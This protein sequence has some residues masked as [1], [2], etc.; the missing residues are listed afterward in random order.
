MLPFTGFTIGTRI[1]QSG[2]ILGPYPKNRNSAVKCYVHEV[3]GL[4]VYKNL[5]TKFLIGVYTDRTVCFIC[6]IPQVAVRPLSEYSNC[7][8]SILTDRLKMNQIERKQL[9]PIFQCILNGIMQ[10]HLIPGTIIQQLGI[11][12]GWYLNQNSGVR[13]YVHVVKRLNSY[14]NLNIEFLIGVDT[15]GEPRFICDIPQAAACPLSKY[16]SYDPNISADKLKMDQIQKNYLDPFF[17]KIVNA[18]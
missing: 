13:C 6:D 1:Q 16:S 2:T 11:K 14:K 10:I 4:D 7:D 18:Y 12:W 9:D 15:N 8:P 17:Q 5:N 3:I